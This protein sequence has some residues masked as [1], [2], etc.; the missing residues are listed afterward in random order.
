MTS[1]SRSGSEMLLLLRSSGLNL[2]GSVVQS[3]ANFLTVVLLERL[4]G[5]ATAF[6]AFLTA[7][8]VINLAAQLGE[9]GTGTGTVR[10]VAR[11]SAA[12]RGLDIR[13]VLGIALVPALTASIALAAALAGFA[14][15]VAPMIAD[16]GAEGAVATY[17]RWF[18]VMVPTM[19]LLASMGQ[20]TRAFGT[21][22][23]A[24]VQ[25][26]IVR[27]GLQTLGLAGLWAL[28][29]G[30]VRV[31]APAYWLPYAIA[32]VGIAVALHRAVRRA[33]PTRVTTD[34]PFGDTASTYWR[35]T[36]PRAVASVFA[37]VVEWGDVLLIAGLASTAQAGIYAAA[38][39]FLVVGRAIQLAAVNALRPQINRLLVDGRTGAAQRTYRLAG[40]WSVALAWPW[41][42]AVAVFAEELLTVLSPEFVVAAPAV[43]I[44]CAAWMVGTALGPVS[45]VLEMAG[46]STWSM[47]DLGLAMVINLGLNVLLVPRL[48][49]TGAAVAWAASLLANNVL[50]AW[51]VA[52]VTGMTPLGPATRGVAGVALACFGLLWAVD[53]AL[54]GGQRH[55][56]FVV[57]AV[58][59]TGLLYLAA[60]WRVGPDLDVRQLASR[61]MDRHAE[62]GHAD[63]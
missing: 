35:Y 22:R 25:L 23:P 40:T 55:L 49:L 32:A 14:D 58:G 63:D 8:A 28:G 50:P 61:V 41:F 20:G 34:V 47:V 19:A 13:R 39:R 48:G 1:G 57:A 10:F 51:Q 17:L 7:V 33:Q 53:T 2:V 38:T 11:S 60:L 3:G 9:L 18:A 26:N 59:A 15:I 24:V 21:M 45:A 52:R 36:A 6:G 4:L 29:V 30:A 44:L 37:A 16:P 54:P 56:W 31:V 43:R 46:R 27:P 12:R 42:L 5:S 62:D